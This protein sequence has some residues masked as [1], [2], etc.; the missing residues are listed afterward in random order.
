MYEQ[1]HFP[2]FAAPAFTQPALEQADLAT[3]GFRL[4]DPARPDPPD[5][6]QLAL[7][8]ANLDRSAP[9]QLDPLLPDL[10]QA[11]SSARLLVPDSEAH[12][13]P[14]PRYEPEVI[15]AQRPGELDLSALVTL[16]DSPD[17]VELPTGITSSDLFTSQDGMNRRNRHLGM[18][19]LGLERAEGDE[20]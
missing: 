15:M 17:R 10:E 12:L 4:P 1:P 6:I 8:P 14:E 20:R 2:D 7:W 16:R 9:E 18:L 3:P 11:A 19:E 5:V 13:M